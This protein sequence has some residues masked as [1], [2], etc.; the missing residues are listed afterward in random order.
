MDLG[1]AEVEPAEVAA[2]GVSAVD[3]KLAI[4]LAALDAPGVGGDVVGLR[5]SFRGRRIR[6]EG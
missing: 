6:G 4:G 5:E 1:P 2:A 3:A